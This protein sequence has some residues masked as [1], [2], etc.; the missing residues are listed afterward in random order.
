MAQ[1]QNK[2]YK[3]LHALSPSVFILNWE[4]RAI[5]EQLRDA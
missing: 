5:Q 2:A 1:A 3:I 4:K